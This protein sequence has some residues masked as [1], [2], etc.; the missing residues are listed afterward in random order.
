MSEVLAFPESG[1][2]PEDA[3]TRA[4]TYVCGLD[5]LA[6]ERGV[7]A[8]VHGEQVA[9]FRV[10]SDTVLAVGNRDPY[11]GANVIS[12]GIVGTRSIPSGLQWF[13]ASPMYKHRFDL[14]SGQALDDPETVLST[15]SVMVWGGRVLVGGQS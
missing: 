1:S 14:R 3:T 8:L 9:L 7:A 4:W 13:V 5:E 10:G 12:R 11:S 6:R 2:V 15:Y